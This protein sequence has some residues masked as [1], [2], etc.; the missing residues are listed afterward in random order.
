MVVKVSV[1]RRPGLQEIEVILLR[2]CGRVFLR[3]FLATAESISSIQLLSELALGRHAK[4][5]FNQDVVK[6]LTDDVKVN[7]ARE[8]IQFERVGRRQDGCA[9]RL[10]TPGRGLLKAAADPEVSIASFAQ[11]G[12]SRPGI[13][14]ATLPETL[15]EEE[16]GGSQSRESKSM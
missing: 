4:P 3:L 7:L 10:Q 5:P 6:R 13:Q 11:G 14:N 9:N 8:S 15:H 12:T 1:L 2:S 16:S